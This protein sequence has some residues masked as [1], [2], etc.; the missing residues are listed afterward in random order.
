MK[1]KPLQKKAAPQPSAE[2]NAL[3]D[4]GRIIAVK[5][6]KRDSKYSVLNTSES[7]HLC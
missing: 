5:K 6:T 4:D 2:P 7:I 3:Q 1:P